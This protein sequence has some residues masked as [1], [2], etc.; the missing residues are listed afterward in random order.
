M[1][2]SRKVHWAFARHTEAKHR[3]LRDYLAAWIPIL[4]SQAQDLVFIDG[5][6]GPGGYSGGAKG[7]PLV[8]LDAYARRADRHR[9]GVV[10]HFFFIEQHEGRAAALR[11]KIDQRKAAPDIRIAVI[12]G[13]YDVEPP[14]LL[15]RLRQRWPQQLPPIFAFIDPFGAQDRLALTGQL[16]TLPRCEA[17]VFVPMGHFARFIHE[18]SIEATMD[19]LFGTASWRRAREQ[20]DVRSRLGVLVPLFRRQLERT[21]TWSRAFEIV[22]R[23]K[24][25]SHFLFFATS[26]P[27]GLA[28]MK[29]AMWKLDPVAGQR[30]R[31]SSNVDHPVLFEPEPDVAPLFN[32]LKDQFGVQAFSIQDAEDFTLF[33]TPFRHDA[34]LKR[35]T[36]ASAE[37]AGRLVP[38]D[39][40]EHRRRCQYPPGTQIRFTG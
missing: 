22:P 5:F 28:K 39:P 19:A 7:S 15:V 11:A 35:L 33:D 13:D 14:D 17:L 30:F 8:M 31:D 4:A 6:A 25:N 40:P 10:G 34:H 2:A 36:L 9:L 38:V 29:E 20:P 24:A 37:R 3:V 18:A 21:A 12:T 26:N 16:L 27:K 23:T 1:A 32:L